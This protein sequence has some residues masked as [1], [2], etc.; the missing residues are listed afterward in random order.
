VTIE[1]GGHFFMGHDAEVRK[2]IGAF[3]QGVT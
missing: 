3:V 1:A 2:A